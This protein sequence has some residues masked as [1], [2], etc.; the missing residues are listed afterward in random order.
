[1]NSLRLREGFEEPEFAQ[2]TG[3]DARGL[4]GSLETL[5]ARNLLEKSHGS[6]RASALGFRFL[7]DVLGEF[8]VPQH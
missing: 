3:L 1:M 5:R 6:W 2:R 8:L 4:I 7:N